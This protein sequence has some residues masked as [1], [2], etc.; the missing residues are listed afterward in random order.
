[1]PASKPAATNL[2]YGD[3]TSPTPFVFP[4]GAR[5]LVY[6]LAAMRAGSTSEQE[7]AMGSSRRWGALALAVLAL[8]G[9][10]GDDEPDA[11]GSASA[12]A[13]SPSATG[14]TSAP[15]TS[16]ATPSASPSD[17]PTTS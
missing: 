15:T 9:C 17:E 5:A 10:S 8:A 12:P 16:A 13:T 6:G 11:P 1:M 3:S 2:R 4:H 7:V 14:T